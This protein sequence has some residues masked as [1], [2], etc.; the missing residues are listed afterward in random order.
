M[1]YVVEES[2]CS[3]YNPSE[4]TITVDSNTRSL[5]VT[6]VVNRPVKKYGR[7]K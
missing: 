3:C 7:I 4:A 5:I 1:R 2:G 6:Y